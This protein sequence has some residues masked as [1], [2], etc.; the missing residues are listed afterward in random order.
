LLLRSAEGKPF[1]A[2]ISQYSR[3]LP[4]CRVVTTLFCSSVFFLFFLFYFYFIFL[5]VPSA[6][7]ACWPWADFP[8]GGGTHVSSRAS[9][10]GQGRGG[11]EEGIVD[12]GG[13]ARAR[14]VAHGV[15]GC[16]VGEW[17]ERPCL[18]CRRGGK[19]LGENQ[20]R[21][22]ACPGG[23]WCVCPC[24]PGRRDWG[25]GLACP[26]AKGSVRPCLPWRKRWDGEDL[27]LACPV[28]R[29]SECS[30]L[31]GRRVLARAAWSS[32]SRLPGQAR[33]VCLPWGRRRHGLVVFRSVGRNEVERWFWSEVNVVGLIFL[34]L[35][36]FTFPFSSCPLLSFFCPIVYSSAGCR[37]G[38]GVGTPRRARPRSCLLACPVGRWSVHSCLPGRKVVRAYSRAGCGGTVKSGNVLLA[39]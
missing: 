31:P 5:A 28:G 14:A 27:V 35:V 25:K 19:G 32:S 4:Q 18:P 24:L 16:P 6:L 23:G 21:A 17:S 33:G 9:K 10:P 13:S 8:C 26:V 2:S 22:L 20:S 12:A 15:L 1:F 36:L 37:G 38:V 30:C 11:G 3:S 7:C 34:L 29:G 39:L